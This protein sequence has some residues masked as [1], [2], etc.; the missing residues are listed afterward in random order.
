MNK[1]T[2]V[3]PFYTKK[4]F[5]LVRVMMYSIYRSNI[6]TNKKTNITKH[7]THTLIFRVMLVIY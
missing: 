2:I 5:Y 6:Q 3:Y 4:K 1:I 7:F